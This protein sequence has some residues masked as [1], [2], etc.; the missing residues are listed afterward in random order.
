[1]AAKGIR[2]VSTTSCTVYS[3]AACTGSTGQHNFGSIRSMRARQPS[4]PSSIGKR[5]M[6]RDGHTI[7]GTGE[8]WETGQVLPF[9]EFQCVALEVGSLFVIA[10]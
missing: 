10:V 8:L 3:F 1:M 5:G 6:E 4:L 9:L 7:D 2:S